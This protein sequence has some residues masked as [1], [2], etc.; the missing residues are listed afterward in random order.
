MRHWLIISVLVG[1]LA[2]AEPSPS[3]TTAPA[4]QATGNATADEA[5]RWR[6]SVGTPGEDGTRPVTATLLAD[7]PIASGFSQVTPK[8]VLR[9]RAGR[10]AAYVL[11]DTFLGEGELAAAVMFG[12]EPPEA[13]K[14]TI[15]SD[16]RAAFIPGDAL[17]FLERLKG[18]PSFAVRIAPRNGQPV[19]VSF[20]L[21]ETELVLKALISAAVKYG[22]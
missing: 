22:G 4:S 7:A 17:A 12:Q 11:F 16:G 13:Q 18:A 19:R 3:S 5:P 8:L 15:S 14:W 20:T 21:H 6:L 10:T 1:S 2:A 9:Y